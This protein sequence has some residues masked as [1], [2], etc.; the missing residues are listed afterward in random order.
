ML[1][2]ETAAELQND[3]A[4]CVC[5]TDQFLFAY[6]LSSASVLV[7]TVCIFGRGPTSG[8][9]RGFEFLACATEKVRKLQYFTEFTGIV[10]VMCL[11][12][13]VKPYLT[14]DFTDFTALCFIL[15]HPR[16]TA[17]WTMMPI[18]VPKVCTFLQFFP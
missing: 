1:Q 13:V 3:E 5:A 14:R 8:L 15:C 17:K 18:G 16:S 2:S 4:S 9:F 6:S 7:A 11:R 10:E 12:I